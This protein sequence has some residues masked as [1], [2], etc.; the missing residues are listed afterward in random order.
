MLSPGNY[1]DLERTELA[2]LFAGSEMV[3]EVLDRIKPFIQET[4]QPN[5]GPIKAR[6]PD[7]VP[8]T[9]VLLDGKLHEDGFRLLPGDTTKGE[10]KVLLEDQEAPEAVVIYGGVCFPDE[11]VEL[12]PG[13]VIETGAVVKGPTII[14]PLTEVRQGAYIRGS[15]LV[16]GRCVVGHVTEL[17]NAVF[18]E[19]AKAGHFAY[20]GD[21]I[22][23]IDVN[24]GAGTKLANLKITTS[25]II[26]NYEG[27]S[28]R[29]NRR[30]F[31]A[32]LGDG[33][34]LGCNTVTSPG[35]VLGPRSLVLPNTTLRVGIHPRRSLFKG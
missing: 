1:F 25:P 29:V 5:L 23:G 4:I 10:F 11:M 26:L 28:F 14:G 31:G 21:S 9:V 2:P 15:C 27:Q 33:C 12:G 7:L 20:C 35:T 32:I 6:F 8:K 22:L 3:W 30:K 24:L 34:E 19:E 17:K 16:A 18:L 13:V